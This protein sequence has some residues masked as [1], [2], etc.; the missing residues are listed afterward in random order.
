MRFRCMFYFLLFHFFLKFGNSSFIITYIINSDLKLYSFYTI[1]FAVGLILHTKVK[2]SFLSRGLQDLFFAHR[3]QNSPLLVQWSLQVFMTSETYQIYHITYQF[4]RWLHHRVL[5]NGLPQPVIRGQV[6]CR[7]LDKNQQSAFNPCSMG[8]AS[9]QGLKI[10]SV[11]N[12]VLHIDYISAIIGN[13]LHLVKVCLRVH[14]HLASRCF[15][16]W[17]EQRH[18]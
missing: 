13:S 7:S 10:L 11:Q 15:C 5:G 1:I 16:C 9:L 3:L 6:R 12:L 8:K 18:C 4:T 2:F 14:L 17:R